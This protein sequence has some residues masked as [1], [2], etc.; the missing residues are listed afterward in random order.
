MLSRSHYA[1][2]T[3]IDAISR[4]SFRKKKKSWICFT[5]NFICRKLLAFCLNYRVGHEQVARLP[6]CTCPCDILSGVSMH[7][8]TI[9][10]Q[11]SK[12]LCCIGYTSTGLDVRS[13]VLM[14]EA[15]TFSIF[16]DGISF[17]HLATVLISVFTLCYGPGLLF[18]GPFCIKR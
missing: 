10:L 11:P 5:D 8:H 18:R 12:S 15:T 2:R 6:F 17:Q 3:I 4:L 9:Q 13:C 14:K 1:K 7:S 16:Y